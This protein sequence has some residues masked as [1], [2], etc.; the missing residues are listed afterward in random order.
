MNENTPE[1]T[2]EESAPARVKLYPNPRAIM[3]SVQGVK[4]TQA[5]QGAARF[6]SYPAAEYIAL[7]RDRI[8]RVRYR[9]TAEEAASLHACLHD[10]A[11]RLVAAVKPQGS[12]AYAV[13][14]KKWLIH[15]ANKIGAYLATLTPEKQ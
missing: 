5:M 9:P 7:L 8:L 12:P 15:F 14:A 2:M 4:L 6:L 3:D 13:N 10:M 11:E 1:T